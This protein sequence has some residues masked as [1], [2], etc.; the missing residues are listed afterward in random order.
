M[1]FLGFPSLTSPLEAALA[2]YQCPFQLKGTTGAQDP[3]PSAQPHHSLVGPRASRTLRVLAAAH[4]PSPP[5][6]R[7]LAGAP[8]RDGSAPRRTRLVP[9]CPRAACSRR[10][11]TER[12]G[13]S[14][15]FNSGQKLG[16]LWVT[17]RLR[18][19][20][21]DVPVGWR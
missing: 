13:C 11:Y 7:R 12:A 8:S 20:E 17:P 2:K 5:T 10:L 19:A 21:Q 1:P 9:R 4:R 16:E 14:L 3:I 18:A 15:M 6:G